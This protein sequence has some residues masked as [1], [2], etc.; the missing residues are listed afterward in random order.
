[1]QPIQCVLQHHIANWH[2]RTWQHNIATFMRPF[3]CHLQ[4]GSQQANRTTHTRRATH[5]RTQRRN[6]SHT[7]TN[8]PHL[9]HT[10]EV[11]FIV[12]RNHITPKS[13]RFRA[14]T[15]SQNKACATCTHPLQCVLQPLVANVNL[16]THM[17]TQHG[18]IYAAIPLP[19]ATRKS[20]SEENYAHT[21][22]R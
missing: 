18:N 22:S 20:T 13:K 17:A 15:T 4:P 14:P 7:K 2:L 16:A 11:P 21:T 9:P 5:C 1:M 12:G 3:H 19:S 8:G 6:Q 10:H